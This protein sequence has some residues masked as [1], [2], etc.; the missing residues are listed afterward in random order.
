MEMKTW[1]VVVLGGY[2]LML[3]ACGPSEQETADLVVTLSNQLIADALTAVPTPTAIEFL[4]HR[5]RDADAAVIEIQD[6]RIL[7][8]TGARSSM[9]DP[10]SSARRI[11]V[12]V[13]T[14]LSRDQYI[15]RPMGSMV[16]LPIGPMSSNSGLK[17]VSIAEP[18]RLARLRTLD[19]SQ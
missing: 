2:A 5:D 9:V 1:L 7:L 14:G 17:T 15:L 3:S 6:K 12:A 13:V 18:S 16:M 11:T 4:I 10:S 8:K 19:D